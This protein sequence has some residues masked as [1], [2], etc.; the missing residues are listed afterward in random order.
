MP[1]KILPDENSD[2]SLSGR[3]EEANDTYFESPIES[4][5]K[6]RILIIT[7]ISFVVLAAGIFSYYF[8]NQSQIDSE[9]LDNTSLKTQEEKMAIKYGVGEFGSDH[10]HSALTVFVH[11]EMLNFALPQFQLQSKY[12]HFEDYNPYLVHKHATGVPL[13]MLFA[14]FGVNVTSKCITLGTVNAITDE[15]FCTDSENSMVFMVNGNNVSDIAQYEIKHNDRIL[16]SLGDPKSLPE[17]LKYLESLQIYDLPKKS[18]ITSEDDI[19]I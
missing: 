10:A 5:P 17:Q 15:K 7:A 3:S 13:E 18:P 6:N 9:I 19:F 4:K 16:I 11:G 12:V 8:V 1:D 14:S 2:Y